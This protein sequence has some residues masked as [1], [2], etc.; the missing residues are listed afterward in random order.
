[1]ALA[2]IHSICLAALEAVRGLLLIKCFRPDRLLQT[3]DLFVQSV[4]E[5]DIS[6]EATYDLGSSVVEEVPAATPVALISVT[7]Y[8]ASYRVEKIL[9]LV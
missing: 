8:D 7:G 5:T 9:E 6:A 1:M 3:T 4:F 2:S